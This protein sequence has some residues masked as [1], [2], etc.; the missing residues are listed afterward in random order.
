[1]QTEA[2]PETLHTGHRERLLARYVGAGAEGFS[3]VELLELLLG[4]AIPRRNVNELAH[5]LLREFGS[6][7]R[8]FDAPYPKLLRVPGVGPR[9]AVLILEVSALWARCEHSR[10]AGCLYLRST[11]ELGRYLLPLARGV[12]EERA[13]LLSL[14]A[15]C[16]LLD[17]RELCRG[18][19][20]SVNLP[21]RKI[22]EAALLANAS[23][24][25]LAHNHTASGLIPSLEDMEYTREAQRVLAMVNV[26]L[27][28]HIIV[29]GGQYLSMKASGMLDL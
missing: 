24:V 19:V 29:S 14:D 25:V 26:I 16:K 10:M 15:A 3:D 11:A 13:W 28:D 9:T 2:K 8:V 7:H 20:N 22:V 6:L 12:A 27:A 5:L 17:C 4:Y 18:A 1:M 21:F 23:S